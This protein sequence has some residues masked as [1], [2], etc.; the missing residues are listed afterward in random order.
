M[1]TIY[2]VGCLYCC[3]G[4]YVLA[5]VKKKKKV[6]ILQNGA[7]T[8]SRQISLGMS[9]IMMCKRSGLNTLPWKQVWTGGGF[10]DL[11]QGWLLLLLP[12]SLF[13]VCVWVG[14]GSNQF[15]SKELYCYYYIKLQLDAVHF[16]I[17]NWSTH[18]PAWMLKPLRVEMNEI[19]YLVTV[20]PIYK[21]Y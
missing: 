8:S 20:P 9:W 11:E 2:N 10:R 16:Y 19:N 17:Y 5:C 6:T 14:F 1:R 13:R 7:C 21:W 18:N 4:I 15:N 12:L 3:V